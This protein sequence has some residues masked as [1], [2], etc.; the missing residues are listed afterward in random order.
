MA[1]KDVETG[2]KLDVRFNSDGLIPAIVQDV[3]SGAVLMLAWMNDAALQATLQSKKA[4]FHS[5][6][7][8]KMWV[9]GESSGHVMHVVEVRVDCDQDAILL[10]CKAAGPACHAGYQ[11]CFY[12]AA[13]AKG[14]LSF[15][16]DKVF[17]PDQVYG[18]S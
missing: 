6:S 10:R 2:D 12:R 5:R 7:R 8:G 14:R 11:S 3:D 13:D 15:V 4:T 1:G 17:D 9:K 18:K 16:E